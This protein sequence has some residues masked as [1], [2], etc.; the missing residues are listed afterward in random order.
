VT[1]V[2]AAACIAFS[3]TFQVYDTDFWQHLLVGRVI[4]QTHAVPH[5]N[6]WSW[7]SYGRPEVTPSWLFRALLWP[8]YAAGGVTGLFVWR[9]ITTLAAF[10]FLWAAARAL[11]GRGLAP[12]FVLTW[13]A[14]IYHGRSQMRPETLAVVLMAA[15]LWLLESRRAR[16]AAGD[17]PRIWRDPL[18]A[19]VPIAWV[20]ANAHASYFIAFVLLGV[21]G[22]ALCWRARGARPLRPVLLAGLAMLAISFANPF[23]WRTLW[24]PFDYAFHLSRETIFRGISE[25]APMNWA[26]NARSG[27]WI[28]IVLWPLLALG[29]ATRRGLDVAEA[30]A[31]VLATAYALPSQRFVGFYAIAAAP[32]VG[33]DVDELFRAWR[34]PAWTSRPAVRTAFA[35]LACVAIGIPEALRPSFTPGVGIQLQKFP[36]A[37]ADFMA[38][39]GVRGR[40]FSHFRQ[41]GY[42]AWRFW[43]DRERLPFTD[44]HQS[45]TP[46]DREAFAEA[47]MAPRET[48]RNIAAHYRLDYAVLD[49]RVGLGAELLDVLD[50]DSAW[51]TVFLDD[52]AALYVR[53]AALPAVADSFA[54]RILGGGQEK[55]RAIAAIDSASWE[56]LRREL[57]RSAAESPW[58][59]RAHAVLTSMALAQGRTG[60]AR[61]HLE[62]VVAVDPSNAQARALLKSLPPVPSRP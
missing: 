4:W 46:A 60:E 55:L 12:L 47:F 48:W 52:D 45:G 1:A 40:G 43:P 41:V 39:H 13:C 19:L 61:E 8:F 62:R 36:V 42:L 29:R 58:N 37:A 56:P 20:W 50:A 25:L 54:Y 32:Y 10:G 11:G 51:A 9:W 38:R 28:L 22:V 15:E 18:L 30:L 24:L 6:L 5:E 27:V 35:A 2:V 23:G 33:R 34:R 31:L 26:N 53:R 16:V 59:S 14:W 3:V 57:E 7:V 17:P 21:H 44:I 49:R